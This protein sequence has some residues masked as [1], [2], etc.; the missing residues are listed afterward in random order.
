MVA[1]CYLRAMTREDKAFNFRIPAK[2]RATLDREAKAHRQS[3][4]A[5]LLTLIETHPDR[6]KARK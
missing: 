1:S 6:S 5:Y 4:N 3:L 2:L